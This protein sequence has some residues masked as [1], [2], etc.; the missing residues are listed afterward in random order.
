MDDTSA[1]RPGLVVMS[2]NVADAVQGTGGLIFDRARLGWHVM[3]LVPTGADARPLAILG[4]E[5]ADMAEVTSRPRQHP[6][7][8][9]A[10]SALY[11]DDR[12]VRSDVESAL[13]TRTTEVLV[14]GR[15]LPSGLER[16]SRS[17]TYRLSAA[18]RVFKAHAMIA[19][20]LATDGM[21]PVETFRTT[22]A[23]N[24]LARELDVAG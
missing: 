11:V 2:K 12:L 23:L 19:A 18:A 22:C 17:V 14:W 8:L 21:E 15:P 13:S 20:G 10:S 1:L 24:V 7:A 5:V 6:T 9:V 4:A 3:V 16:D